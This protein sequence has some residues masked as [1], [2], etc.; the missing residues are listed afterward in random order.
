MNAEK[1]LKLARRFIELPLEK[2]RL[3]LDG[4]RGEGI[5]F[6]QFPI[7]KE[8]VQDDR[9][10]LSYA[11]RRMWF[12]WQ[13]DPQSAA[14]HIPAALRL[15]G[16]LNIEALQRSFDALLERHHSLRSV[17]VEPDPQ[18]AGDDSQPPSRTFKVAASVQ[19]LA[20]SGPW[21]TLARHDL[22]D[23]PHHQ[24]LDQALTLLEDDIARLGGPKPG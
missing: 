14:Y 6:S 5:D 23:L 10:A 4:L 2:R 12:L 7:P 15:R 20:A 3:F 18:A 16:A 19:P 8:V 13:L 24:R 17:F 1:S 11:Q 22:R 9:H 21:L